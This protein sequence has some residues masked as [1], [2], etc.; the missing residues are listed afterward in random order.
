VISFACFTSVRHARC[1]ARSEDS[2][3]QA[4]FAIHSTCNTGCT[5]SPRNSHPSDSLLE[6]A[7]N[8]SA[9]SRNSSHVIVPGPSMVHVSARG[10]EI[11]RDYL[12]LALEEFSRARIARCDAILAWF[13][14]AQR[15]RSLASLGYFRDSERGKRDKD[16]SDDRCDSR[17]HRRVPHSSFSF[18]SLSLS[19]SLVE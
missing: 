19:L 1:A 18:L 16:G 12:F 6:T 17:S 10:L 15:A 3:E 9:F 13:V 8:L 5:L 4:G 7:R 14:I 2:R 11:L